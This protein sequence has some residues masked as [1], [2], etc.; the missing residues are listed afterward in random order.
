MDDHDL[1]SLDELT[2][3]IGSQ[4]VKLARNSI[5]KKLGIQGISEVELS[6]ILN[7]KGMAF[8]TLE[9]NDVHRS[10]R[11]CI[12]YVQAV[13]PLKDVVKRAAEAAAFSDPR[14][15]PLE[16]HE[17]DDILI[18]VTVLTSPKEI[19]GNKIDLPS[20][21]EIGVDGLIVEKGMLYSGLLLPQVPIE[22][23]WD[24]ETF[25]A[26]T[27]IKASLEPDCWLDESVKIKKFSGKIFKEKYPKGDIFEV[28]LKAVTK[29]RE[30]KIV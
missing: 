10:L 28:N 22:Y 21:I 3:D 16:K 17:I 8:V 30:N 27:C 9:R 2:I 26:E 11:G 19:Q 18:E 15:P 6:P 7:K 24:E 5:M 23:N 20:K 13:Y 12:G 1:V 25:L 14:F 29:P 4:L